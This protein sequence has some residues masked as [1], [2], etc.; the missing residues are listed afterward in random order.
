MTAIRAELPGVIESLL[1]D[2]HDGGG[3][4]R[5]YSRKIPSADRT[6]RDARVRSMLAA[7]TPPEIIAVEVG[8]SR[9]HVYRLRKSAERQRAGAPCQSAP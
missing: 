7:G 8:C 1:H 5:L 6:R 4:V 2:M 3:T 9:T